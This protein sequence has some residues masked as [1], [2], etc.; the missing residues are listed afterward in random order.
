VLEVG[1]VGLP[2]D[3]WGEIVAAVV[4]LRDGAT[5]GEDELRAHARRS[6]A[7]YKVPERIYFMPAL[8]KGPTGKVHRQALKDALLGTAS[9]RTI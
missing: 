2:H 4:A 3:V 6:L 5:V 1:V 9:P 7:D 8:P